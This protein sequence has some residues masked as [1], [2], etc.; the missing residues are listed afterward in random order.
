MVTQWREWSAEEAARGWDAALMTLPGYSI[1]Q[2]YGWGEVKRHGGWTVRRGSVMVDGASA[3]MAQCL[4]REARWV[5]TALIWTPGGPA[6]SASGRLQLG[7]ALR[8]RYP[9]WRLTLR[10]NF[11]TEATQEETAGLRETGWVRAATPLAWPLSF[12]VDLLRDD[13]VLRRALTKNW[14][15]NLTRGEERGAVVQVWGADRALEP[16]Y[17]VYAATAR[18]KRIARSISLESLQAM[19]RSLGAAFTIAAALDIDGRPCA[20]RGFGRIGG[21]AYDLVAGVSEAGRKRYANYPLMWRTLALAKEQGAALYDMGSA[22]PEGAPGVYH[23]KKGIGGRQ[24][25]LTGEWDWAT[26]GWLRRGLDAAIRC[27][28]GR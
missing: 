23:F 3:A 13:Q 26:S 9:G 5:K 28:P 10:S 20:V 19:R 12:H 11:L 17:A 15:H 27:W 7:D 8:A 16:V 25:A 6:G 1:Y 18:L 2:S 14:R 22:H 21:R 24:V 4:V